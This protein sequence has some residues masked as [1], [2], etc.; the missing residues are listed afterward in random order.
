MKLLRTYLQT[1]I[2]FIYR[3]WNSLIILTRTVVF[4]RLRQEWRL[5]AILLFAMT[6][7]TGF[8]ALGPLY[9][10]TVTEADLRYALENADPDE[11]RLMFI[12][13]SE[14]TAEMQAT[15]EEDLGPL[16]VDVERYKR[17]R[18][19]PPDPSATQGAA[20][21]A[22]RSV[23]GIQFIIGLD[24]RFN[25]GNTGN[26]YQP[27]A[28]E[29]LSEK[30]QVV[31]GRLPVRGPTPA[32]LSTSGTNP[33]Q[34]QALQIGEYT[35]GEVEAVVTTEV[36]ENAGLEVGSRFFI[37]WRDAQFN[38]ELSAVKIVGIVEVNDPNDSFWEGNGMFV[39][40]ATVDIN[41]F[42]QRY[43]YGMAFHMAAY[44]DWIT[45]V[46]PSGLG[47]E[48]VWRMDVDTEVIT[49][50]N[51]SQYLDALNGLSGKLSAPPNN[52]TVGSELFSI[53]SGYDAR[54]EDTQGPVILLSS[55]ILVMMLYHLI[56]TVTLVLQQQGKEWSTIT[57]RGGS[58]MQLFTM[59]GVT[60]IFLAVAAFLLGPLLS[61]GFM[62]F[63]E[64]NGPLAEGLGGVSVGSIPIPRDSIFL[65]VAAAVAAVVVLSIPAIPA[66]RRSLLA[67]KQS[68]SRPPTR[69][70]WARY[71][72]DLVLIGLGVALMV[73]LYLTV[74][75]K[76]EGV[77][78]LLADLLE[79]PAEVVRFVADNANKHGGLSD[80]FNVIAPAMVLTGLALFWLRLFPMM[81]GFLSRLTSRSNQLATPLAVW[82]VERDPNHYAQL[83]LLLIGTLA[84]GTASL[85]LRA[86][87]DYGGWNEARQQVGGTVRVDLDSSA[88]RYGDTNWDDLDGVANST[89]ILLTSG[90]AVQ[91]RSGTVNVVGIDPADFVATFPDYEDLVADLQGFSIEPAGIVLPESA[92]QLQVQVWS[93]STLNADQEIPEA[94]VV[95]NA[96]VLDANGVPFRVEMFQQTLGDAGD[97]ADAGGQTVQTGPI[98]TTPGRWVTLSGSL[99]VRG[100][101]PYRLWRVGMDTVVG[102]ED[103]FTHTVYLDY[104]QTVDSNGTTTIVENQE[105]PTLWQPAISRW[106]Y[107]GEWM[108]S[109]AQQVGGIEEFSFVAAAAGEV[110][111]GDQALKLTYR[112]ERT[113]SSDNEPSIGIQQRMMPRVPVVITEYFAEDFKRGGSRNIRT[114]AL[115]IGDDRTVQ[116]DLP[117]GRTVLGTT[118]VNIVEEF[119]SLSSE[120]LAERYVVIM[121]IDAA[122]VL[123][124][125]PLLDENAIVTYSDVNQVWLDLEERE[126]TAAFKDQIGRLD[127]VLNASYAY[128][129]Y[130]EILREP[131]PSAVAGMLYAGFWVSLILSLLDFAF[132]IAVTAKQRSFTFG[133]LRSLGWNTNNIWR[134]LLVEQMTLVTPALIIGSILGAGLAYLLLPFL[135]LIG[136]ATLRMPIL[137]LFGLLL[138]LIIGF[139]I[140][141]IFTALWL[142]RMSVNQVL[143]LGEE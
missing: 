106:P 92:A 137:S 107:P 10:R 15:I 89:P 95:L 42:T 128:D 68:T 79:S 7:I 102:D 104:W 134:M 131:L 36:A 70:V 25:A 9:I 100:T 26:C 83:V 48:Y 43:D 133:V 55:A 127:M 58:T 12:S 72:V 80:P 28:F 45:P 124:N 108:V 60:M 74:S 13:N 120:E 97:T 11:L 66:A 141:L 114:P 117:T 118:V 84:L 111:D 126:A 5:L 38:G 103:I 46:M 136:S 4:K 88:G 52:V 77:G 8:F 1:V 19:S 130:T 135:S 35:R 21:N 87:R 90:R 129:R 14:M 53:L 44:E 57:S 123:T 41:N 63:M 93:E 140:L 125:Q 2:N 112:I 34:R 143:R 18:Y 61:R 78:Q 101:P 40:G 17:A 99:P 33:E 6:L 51:N 138:T 109:T 119:P 29:N 81:M 31:A 142:R 67:L 82:N 132:Y 122:R 94:A 50:T 98:T 30:V 49:S 16:V 96:Y 105:N 20:G 69:P 59:Q 71:F 54:V 139:T 85:G 86:T 37:G 32:D 113:V 121:P 47:T 75:D 23:C 3:E 91:D 73:R 22:G 64:K 110:F 24:P 27:F 65:S 62:F 116:V 76:Q 39:R 115:T 56:T